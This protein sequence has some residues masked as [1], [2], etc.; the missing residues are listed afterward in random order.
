MTSDVGYGRRDLLL[1]LY[2]VAF[3]DKAFFVL[4]T[5]VRVDF[6]VAE[7]ALPTKFA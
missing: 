7:E 4:L 2:F 1:V 6:V 3:A 5:H